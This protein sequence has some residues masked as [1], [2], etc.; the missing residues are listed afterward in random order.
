MIKIDF[1]KPHIS[2]R[3]SEGKVIG[4]VTTILNVLNKP[5]LIPWA[6]ARGQQGVSL[7][8]SRDKAANIGTIVHA[9]IMAYY[10]GEEIDNSNIAP[11]IWGMTNNSLQSF[12]EWTKNRDIKPIIVEKPMIS[13]KYG[14]GGT[15]DIFGEMDGEPTLLDFKTGS[16]IY[17]EHF[18]QIAAYLQLFK[19][20]GCIVQKIVILNI[21]KTQ[22]DYFSIQS[23]SAD[24][25]LMDLRFR[26]FI[27]VLDIYNLDREIKKLKKGE[28]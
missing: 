18:I 7:Y 9:R 13:E 27:K 3:N 10:R 15:P 20:A 1:E 14:Y 12:F 28:I 5:A 26:K 24:G 23:I 16:G 2:Y 22:D 21:P 6:Y 11:D 4:G 8:G 17:E 19:E 25:P